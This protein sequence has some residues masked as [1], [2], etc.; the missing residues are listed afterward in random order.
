M[1]KIL[2]FIL[3]LFMN[4]NL[5]S[6]SYVRFPQDS[7]VWNCLLWHQWAPNR[8]VLK[9]STYLLG[10]D[11]MLNGEF[12]K[13]VYY[14]D[15]NSMVDP[16][17]YIGGLRE[18]INKNIYFFPRFI[19]LENAYGITQFP[20]NTSEHLLYTFNNLQVGMVLP[21]NQG[22]TTIHLDAIDSVLV[23]DTYRKRYHINQENLL[24]LDY[25]IEGIGSVKDLF[26][27]YSYEF[28]W[29]FYTL[30]FTDTVTYYINTPTGD[31]CCY[32]STPA[33]TAELTNEDG[34]LF[35]NP[36]SKT[37]YLRNCTSEEGCL[38]RMYNAMGQVVMLR[39]I[40]GSGD[41]IDVERLQAGVYFIEFIQTNRKQYMKF[42]K[43]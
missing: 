10:G 11:T 36:V 23:G 38:L 37:L 19:H 21:I 3:G 26:I 4:I 32:Y 20:N 6:Q 39:K 27:T 28:E 22:V 13:K 14:D 41:D 18:D 40:T 8:I 1:K 7:A 16:P 12:Y 33:A 35:P 34:R 43:E 9:N 15:P 17:K 25:W 42:I 24:E 2:I 29:R 5:N 30:C 31:N